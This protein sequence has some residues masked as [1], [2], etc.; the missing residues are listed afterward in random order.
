MSL[1]DRGANGG[2]CLDELRRILLSDRTINIQG[3][4][5]HQLH[6]LSIGTFGATARTQRGT[7]ILIFHQYAYH[8]RGKS[9]HS[10]LQ[11]K[12]NGVTVNDRPMS[13]N[14]DQSLITADGY[15][16]PLDFKNGRAYLNLRPFT[17]DE[18]ETYPMS[19]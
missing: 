8:G 7:V 10:S 19:S 18:F 1:I 14:G 12:D 5:N 3:I 15:A 11:L 13:L 4:D 6:G 9:I 16:I 2:I 17:E